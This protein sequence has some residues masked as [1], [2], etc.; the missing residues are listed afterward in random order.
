MKN[1]F[2]GVVLVIISIQCQMAHQ[3]KEIP[4]LVEKMLTLDTVP[5]GSGLAVV[6]DSI[7]IVGDDSPWLFQYSTDYRPL[8]RYL[9]V[10]GFPLEGRIPKPVKPDFECLAEATE[11]E[12]TL[13]L[14]FGSG[15]KS[16]ERD[17]LIKVD[18]QQP[19]DPQ[20][21]S[22][23]AFYDHLLSIM[24]GTRADLNIEAAVVIG[25][26]LYLFNRGDNSIFVVDW[27]NLLENLPNEQALQE[28]DIRQYKVE[29]PER[30]GVSAG[31]S[32]ACA[33]P[34]Q[35]S[36]IF[37]ATLEATENWIADGE[38]LGSYLGVLEVS[39]LQEGR[40][41]SIWLIEDSEGS[42]IKDKLESVAILDE[43]PAGD[44]KALAVA[45]ND[46]GTSK[47]LELRIARSFLE[48]SQ[49]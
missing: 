20:I 3:E 19:N 7:F 32:G 4:V 42:P 44:I 6:D 49:R 47:L 15:S 22:L 31:L 40:V 35:S 18:V 11:G 13:L 1:F 2:W 25:K 34:D 21:F 5:S 46:D 12:S 23:T 26:D 30:E 37:T 27:R 29:L 39:K 8:G 43:S 28:L 48:A 36:L 33:S 24:E 10:S 17:M 45:D 41:A 38:I 9:L 16:P 14:I